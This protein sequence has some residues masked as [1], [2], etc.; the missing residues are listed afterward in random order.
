MPDEEK[1]VWERFPRQAKSGKSAALLENYEKDLSE[2]KTELAKSQEAPE[3][4]K[5]LAELRV[6]NAEKNMELFFR[7]HDSTGS[8]KGER[9]HRDVAESLR[10]R[11]IERNELGDIEATED[12]E[13]SHVLIVNM[14]ELDRLNNIGGHEMGDQ[15]LRLTL[16]LVENVIRE[17]I[18]SLPR[19]KNDE[20]RLSSV[21]DIYR[22]SGND[23]TVT[24]H[25]IEEDLARDI[26]SRISNESV[27]FS[28]LRPDI[29]PAPLTVNRVTRADAI[30]LVN[31]LDEKPES[32]GLTDEGILIDAMREKLQTLND[33]AKIENRTRHMVEKIR[34]AGND[35]EAEAKVK[36]F[37]ETFIKKSIGSVFRVDPSTESAKYVEFRNLL[38]NKRA[39]D[40]PPPDEWTHFLKESA[41]D[42]AFEQLKARRAVGRNIEINLA[43]KVA[44]E[45]LGRTEEFGRDILTEQTLA[46][47]RGFVDPV[48]TSGKLLLNEKKKNAEQQAEKD[49]S[50]PIA[51][52]E[53]EGAQL[54]YQIELA[55]RNEQTGLNGRGVYFE[56][57]EV[58]FESGRPVATIAIDMAF[59]KYFD[60]EGGPNTGNMAILKTAEIMDKIAIENTKEGIEVAAHRTG[61][62]EFA[63]TVIGGDKETVGKIVDSVR[64]AARSVGGIPPSSGAKATYSPERLQ[65]NYGIR[66]T[67]S[68]E[69]LRD[70]LSKAG[71]ELPENADARVAADYLQHL[72]DK[73]IDIQKGVDRI[74]LLL[75][76]KFEE[77]QTG[78]KRNYE[79]LMEYSH[80]AIFKENGKK[81]MASLE[82]EFI[83]P[84]KDENG[85]EIQKNI[86]EEMRKLT[87]EV[88]GFVIEEIEKKSADKKHIGAELDRLIENAVKIRYLEN[89]IKVLEREIAELHMLHRKDES[90]LR[91]AEE[92]LVSV[93]RLRDRINPPAA[94]SGGPP[95][96]Q[97]A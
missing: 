28:S 16:E 94:G 62:D 8:W 55:K 22:Y 95:Q 5:K 73:E 13:K 54:D 41:L 89:H 24:L 92:E 67:E 27:D 34:E 25:G 32:A 26:E 93:K 2:K 48:D 11:R 17:E 69:A 7:E 74:L 51:R 39:F 53:Y 80:K 57:M 64:N 29:E 56:T 33:A 76:R 58:G 1:S 49:T 19:F 46:S 21:Y 83:K 81:F 82:A 70:E 61:G 65:F 37:Y 59:L 36:E 20:P 43:R 31:K 97:A 86:E 14:G 30:A 79:Q 72:A 63:L 90:S 88:M 9:F 96:M 6:Q 3:Q 4:E 68:V 78:E 12:D 75:A 15:G 10:D 52:E 60:K 44:D 42:G 66:R 47:L 91:A 38:D 23:F 87:G 77:I 85:N 40:V 18:G 45:V 50:D 84:K 71:I 35:P